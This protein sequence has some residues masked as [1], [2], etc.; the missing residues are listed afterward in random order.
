MN[1]GTDASSKA[2]SVA[3]YLIFFDKV[4]RHK[5]TEERI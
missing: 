4:H 3:T 2:L 5:I 1:G